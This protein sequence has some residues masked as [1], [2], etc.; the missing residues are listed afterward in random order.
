M[1]RRTCCSARLARGAHAAAQGWHGG[2]PP[3]LAWSSGTAA[4][5][6]AAALP[7]STTLACDATARGMHHETKCEMHV[8]GCSL[9]RCQPRHI[10]AGD[11]MH[12]LGRGKETDKQQ[13]HINASTRPWCAHTRCVLVAT[14]FCTACR[15]RMMRS[16]MS[17]PSV[18]MYVTAC[19]HS[20]RQAGVQWRMPSDTG[21]LAR[22]RWRG[23]ERVRGQLKWRAGARF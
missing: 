18:C 19:M 13:R 16:C 23:G 7:C 10:K 6:T 3:R 5:T 2:H 20:G 11:S 1:H 17:L 21:S 14:T 15:L 8:L 22:T 9:Q 12:L 4:I